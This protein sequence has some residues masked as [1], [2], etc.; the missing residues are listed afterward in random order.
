VGLRA[1][2]YSEAPAFFQSLRQ[3]AGVSARCLELLLLT[4]AR[5]S[6][7]LFLQ[8]GELDLEG[9]RWVVPAER[10]KAGEAHEVFL[11]PRA[12][13]L[14]KE[15][16]ALKL[17]PTLVFPSLT[18]GG[19]GP[20]SNM[21]LLAVLNRMGHRDRT[22]VHGLRASFSTWS[23]ET[24]AARPDVIEACLAHSERDKVKKAYNRAEFASDRRALLQ[25][26]ADFLQTPAARAVPLAA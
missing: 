4:A 14:L 11:P 13:Q 22:T 24:A 9:A 18:K 6:E 25:A 3:Q 20:M 1:L 17:H 21:A 19:D 23:Y 7:A 2:P 10:M 15:Q 16:I 26:W 8:I 12:V 5:T